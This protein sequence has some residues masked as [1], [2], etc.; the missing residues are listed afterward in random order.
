MVP[1]G[2]GKPFAG[3]SKPTTSELQ[4]RPMDIISVNYVGFGAGLP[5][6][7]IDGIDASV[8]KPGG[9]VIFHVLHQELGWHRARAEAR[10]GARDGGGLL[11][12]HIVA[13]A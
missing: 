2:S 7:A 3:A 11:L 8:W 12:S 10:G 6:S 13:M 4:S 9:G 5:M 1:D